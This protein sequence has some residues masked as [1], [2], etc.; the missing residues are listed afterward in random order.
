MIPGTGNDTL[1]LVLEIGIV[2]ALLV[3]IVLMIR[4]YRDR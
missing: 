3:M 2:L 1:D 4:N